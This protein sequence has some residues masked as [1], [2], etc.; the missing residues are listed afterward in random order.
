MAIIK[1]PITKGK[2]T[3]DLD[4]N[5]LP[6]AVYAAFVIEGAKQYLNKGMTKITKEFY[7]DSKKTPED[8][9]AELAQAAMTKAAENLTKLMAGNLGRAKSTATKGISG[10][11]MTE[12]RRI[13][14]N[15]VKDQMKAEGLKV[16][17][18]KASEITAAANSLIAAQPEIVE[19]AKAS[20]DER[21]KVKIG[22]DVKGIPVDQGLVAKIE[23]EKV[24]KAKDKPLS[25]K[26]AGKTTKHKPSA[27]TAH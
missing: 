14:R 26:Q 5:A 2:G 17:H 24:A 10:A 25:A 16:S 20:L 22:I 3:I 13:A 12:A 6:E 8:N 21:G 11:V 18:Y 15:M 27:A 1:V 19:M 4:T 23:A 7:S 9:A